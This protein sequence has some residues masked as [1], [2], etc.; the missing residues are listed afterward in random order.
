MILNINI[1][2]YFLNSF[3]CQLLHFTFKRAHD[4]DSW[5]FNLNRK[6]T[7]TLI[8]KDLQETQLFFNSMYFELGTSKI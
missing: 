1:L 8:K 7:F 6:N 4:E 2:R 3:L 5:C